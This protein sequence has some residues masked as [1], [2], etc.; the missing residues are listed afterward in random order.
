MGEGVKNLQ[1]P[2]NVVYG[3]P[4]CILY[5]FMKGEGVGGGKGIIWPSMIELNF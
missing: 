3:C 1:N 2:I 5:A 4:L